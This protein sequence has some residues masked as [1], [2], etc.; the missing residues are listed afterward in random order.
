MALELDLFSILASL[1]LLAVV[2]VSG[3]LWYLHFRYAESRILPEDQVP[4]WPIGWVNFGIF[5]CIL[6]AAISLVPLFGSLFIQDAIQAADGE[7]TPFIAIYKILLSQ[8]PMLGVFYGLRRFYPGLYA[9]R[10]SANTLTLG[11][12]IWKTLPLFIK[13]LPLVW[14][15]AMFWSSLIAALEHTGIIGEQKSQE[16]VELFKSGG[17]FVEI[18][19][20]FV[21]A[22]F[23]APLVEEI[24]FRGCIYRFL[25]SKAARLPAQIFSATLFGLMH[26]NLLALFPLIVVGIILAHIYEK[27]GSIYVPICFHACFNAFSLIMLFLLS[28][29]KFGI[30]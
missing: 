21:L 12:A 30:G 25:K 4:S 15:A 27:S 11:E 1:I 19:I 2:C 5:I 14:I 22:V 13:L 24:I 26:Q 8:L 7:L 9:G 6:L 23:L 16:L 20:L 28:H 3:F 10:L 18:L 17:G 29:S